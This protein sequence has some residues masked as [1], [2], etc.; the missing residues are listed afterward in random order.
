MLPRFPKED[1]KHLATE[2]PI[3]YFS[4]INTLPLSLQVIKTETKKYPVLSK[5]LNYTMNGWP[6]HNTDETRKDYFI[7]RR[8]LTGDQGCLLWRLRVII[9]SCHVT[10]KG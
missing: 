3:N 8:E 10:E 6:N 9:P 5:L 2:L 1:E 4:Y 7:W